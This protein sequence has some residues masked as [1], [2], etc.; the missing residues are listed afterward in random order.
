MIKAVIFDWGGVLIDNPTQGMI[1]YMARALGIS[2]NVVYN[3]VDQAL[4]IQFQKGKVSEDTVWEKVCAAFNVMKPVR[5]SLWK[6]AFKEVY[7]PRKDVFSLVHD[8]KNAGYK[9]GFLSNTEAPA[10]EF[11]FEQQ[12]DFF[13]EVVF[14]CAEGTVK[15]EAS[16]YAITLDRLGVSP[17]QAVFIDDRADFIAGAQAVGMHGILFEHAGQVRAALVSMGVVFLEENA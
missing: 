7:R 12:Y 13:D 14:S 3:G 10:M 16:I 1:D 8:L 6:D 17:P 15:P 5:P 2:K 9:L 4:M 11:F